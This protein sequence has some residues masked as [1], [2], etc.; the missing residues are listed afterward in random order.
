MMNSFGFVVYLTLGIIESYNII[1]RERK[2]TMEVCCLLNSVTSEGKYCDLTRTFQNFIAQHRNRKPCNIVIGRVRPTTKNGFAQL[3]GYTPTNTK[4]WL[5]AYIFDIR[6]PYYAQL[7]PV[8]T[9]YPLTS[10]TWPYRGLKY[11]FSIGSRAQA[12]LTCNQSWV[13]R[14]PVN[15]Q[16]RLN[17][18]RNVK[19][20]CIKMFFTAYVLCNLRVI[21]TQK[22]R[23]NNINKVLRNSFFSLI[24]GKVISGFEQIGPGAPLSG[25]ARST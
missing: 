18:N 23:P 14:K 16:P 3:G 22:R 4:S 5:T 7:T 1:K 25:L 19:F 10:I 17:V 6:H 24:L 11:W 20:P 12:T 15:A 13:F 2:T 21:H 8:K 9:R